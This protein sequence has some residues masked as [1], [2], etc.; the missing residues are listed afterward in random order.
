VSQAPRIYAHRGDSAGAPE[1]T[2]A[3]FRRA[4]ESGADGVELDVHL[5]AT[6][7]VVVVHDYGLAR[8]TGL[9]AQVEHTPWSTIRALDAGSWYE[10]RFAGERVPLLAE[11]FSALG[12]RVHYDVEIKWTPRGIGP[13]EERVVREIERH[14]LG[15][16]CVVSSFHPIAVRAVHRIEPALPTAV[17]YSG[18]AP[19][20][21]YLRRG[22][23]RH[24]SKSRILKPEHTLVNDRT[25]RRSVRQGLAVFA[26]TVDDPAE[27]HRLASL[28]V[29]GIITN[30]PGRILA[31]LGRPLPGP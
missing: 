4:L 22:Q 31:A 8:T 13:L 9:D 2:L 29:H 21:F 1:N 16:H 11:V 25:I 27:A 28:G 14:G 18:R 23:G 20:P 12:N 15:A 3:A 7:E 30:D 26:W 6:G 17:I 10:P 5:C 24:L 19:M